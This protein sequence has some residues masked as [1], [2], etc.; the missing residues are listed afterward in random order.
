MGMSRKRKDK[1]KAAHP[2]CIFCGGTAEA[3]TIEHCPPRSMFQRREWPEGFEFPA[4]SDCNHGSADDDLLV[5][6]L[7]RTDP[8]NDTGSI[9]GRMP[10]IISSVIQ[11]FPGIIDRMMPTANEARRINN[12]LGIA[13][14]PGK[15]NQEAGAVHV[16]D[17]MHQA[18][19]VFAR[20]LL[21]AIYYL[22]TNRP[23]PPASR[24]VMRWFT[25]SELITNEGRYSIFDILS[26]LEGVAP[27]LRRAQTFLNDQFSYK[28]SLSND[29]EL[30]LLQARF[31]QGFGFLVIGSV[32]PEK[33]DTLFARLEESTQKPNPFTIL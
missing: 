17:E 1:F 27:Q 8:F 20:K 32:V 25:N 3:T 26:E 28:V 2:F 15:T 6:F 12:R 31:G 11:K 18:V 14:P 13:P 33:L 9:D 10:L 21:K 19:E 30:I 7:A 24:L 29:A 5:A 23:F 4:C 22:H 16:V